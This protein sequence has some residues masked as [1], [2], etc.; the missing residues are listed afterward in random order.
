LKGSILPRE[1]TQLK[2]NAWNFLGIFEKK[3]KFERKCSA[4][5]RDQLKEN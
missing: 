5:G 4:K 3:F 2:E 1:V